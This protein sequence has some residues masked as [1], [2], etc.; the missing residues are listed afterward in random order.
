MEVILLEK[1]A[2][3]GN[4]GDKVNVKSGYA[5]NH[6]IPYG[7]VILAT[8]E[9]LKKFEEHRAELEKAAQ[10]VLAKAQER[11]KTLENLQLTV[12]ANASEE[13]K[14]FGSIGPREIAKA[15]QAQNIV[16]EKSEIDM[17]EG[18]IHQVGEHEV[19]AHLHSDVVVKFKVLVAAEMHEEKTA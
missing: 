13:G 6:L 5:R 3:L 8:A 2:N 19:A 4:V 14:L 10:E 9:N 17:P 18:P 11:A 7:K 1:I 15:A 12:T 16:L